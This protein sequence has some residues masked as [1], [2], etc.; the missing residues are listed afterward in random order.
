MKLGAVGGAWS[1]RE[2]QEDL[3]N[4]GHVYWGSPE[5]RN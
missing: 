5:K 4:D 1:A 2:Q 3:G